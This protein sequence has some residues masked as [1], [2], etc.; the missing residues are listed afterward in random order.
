L[1]SS[2]ATGFH[3]GARVWFLIGVMQPLS[4]RIG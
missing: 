4:N 3:S 2:G 1:K